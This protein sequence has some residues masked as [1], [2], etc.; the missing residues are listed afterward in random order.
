MQ[1]CHLIWSK[2]R[3]VFSDENISYS[4][5][6]LSHLI[7]ND[8][9]NVKTNIVYVNV[10]S[11]TIHNSPKVDT[12]RMSSHLW[13]DKHHT[14]CLLSGKLLSNEKERTSD[15]YYKMHEPKKHYYAQW[16]KRVYIF[17]DSIYRKYSEKAN[18]QRQKVS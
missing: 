18:L 11:I 4:N 10:Q 2:I 7:I 9:C 13:M 14:V 3:F 6:W 15:K 17:Y 5:F 1:K 8:L 12:T 16:K